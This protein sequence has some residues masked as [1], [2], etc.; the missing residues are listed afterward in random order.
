MNLCD[1]LQQL[2]QLLSTVKI[3]DDW[4]RLL[5]DLKGMVLRD[6]NTDFAKPAVASMLKLCSPKQVSYDKQECG[7]AL[8][9]TISLM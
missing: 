8:T 4:N 9:C 6:V 5:N 2:A 3:P 1:D 7:D